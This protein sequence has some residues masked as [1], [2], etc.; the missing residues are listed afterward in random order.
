VP[1]RLPR[2]QFSALLPIGKRVLGVQCTSPANTVAPAVSAPSPAYVGNVITT[3]S[4]SWSC[5]P[6]AYHYQWLRNGAAI[7]GATASSYTIQAG[8]ADVGATIRSSVQ[9]C[10]GIDCSSYVQSSN[11]VVPANR[12]P[13]APTNLVPAN[14]TI[15]NVLTPTLSGTFSDP[16]GQ[17]GYISFTVNR[18]A[19]GALVTNGSSTPQVNSGATAS[20]AVPANKLVPGAQY[21]WYAQAGD[22]SGASSSSVGPR[23]YSVPPAAP[24]LVTPTSGASVSTATPV[25]SASPGSGNAGSDPLSYQ[26][27]LATDPGFGFNT[28]V[29]DG[30]WTTTTTTW[31]VPAGLLKDGQTYYW[32]ARACGRACPD[33][34]SA[35]S[36]GQSLQ[37]RLPKL[38]IR[39]YWPIWSRGPL[40]VNEANGNL[41]LSVPGPSYPTAAGSM[42]ASLSYNSQSSAPDSGFG[43]G[44]ALNAG[45]DGSSPP[46]KLIDHNQS[47]ASPRFDA[48]ERI[49]ADGSTDYYSHVGSSNTYLAAPG[50]GAQL[51][52]NG[53]GSWTLLDS[54]GAI[55][56]FNPAASNGSATLKSAERVDASPGK[57]SLSYSFSTVDP[58]KI[59]SIADGQPGDPGL[60][61]LS[62]AWHSL[63]DT[64]TCTGAILCISG[65]DNVA[66]KY[67][68][69]GPNGES[70][71]LVR[72]NDGAR[73]LLQLGYSGSLVT[74]VK[75]ANDL[76]PTHA[77]PNYNGAHSLAITYQACPSSTAQC[78]IKVDDGPVTNQTPA[79]SSWSFVYH[80]G[81]V[82]PTAPRASHYQQLV[83]GDG[84]LGYWPLDE[85]GG[86]TAADASG[87]A[88]NGTYSGTYT[89]G[90]SGAL[91]GSGGG[92]AVGFSGGTVAG[93][94]PN[95]NLAAGA[96]NTVELWLNWNGTDGVMP[97]GFAGGGNYYDLF[98]SGGNF[99]FNTGCSD[100][101]G[102]TAPS[103]N[104]WHHVVAQFYNGDPRSGA[105]LWID[106]NQQSLTL[107]TG[108]PCS[109]TVTSSFDISGWPYTSAY[110][111]G[112][113]VD[114]VAIYPDALSPVAIKAHYEEGKHNRAA[115]GYTTLTPPR[116]QTQSCPSKCV[117]TYYDSL[118]HPIETLDILGNISESAYNAK[119]EL[120]WSEDAD[121]N[122]TD[123]LY[124]GPDGRTT[125]NPFI[126]DAL[127]RT[128]AP[129][130]DGAGALGRPVSSSRY[131]ETQIG[132][133]STAGAALQGLQASY[134]GN[135]NLAGRATTIENNSTIDYS[136]PSGGPPELPNVIHNFS[137][138][139]SGDLLVS[140]PG[141]YTFSEATS[142]GGTRLTID[143]AQAIDSWTTAAAAPPS[144]PIALAA[145]LHKLVFEYFDDGAP[146]LPQIH[147]HWACGGCSPQVADQVIP[148]L[149][150][151]P[152]WFNQTST[153]SAG[154]RLSF[155]H[156]A[157]PAAAHSD[158][159]LVQVGAT[160]LIT[161][162]LYDA[163][164]RVTQKV[165]PKGNADPSRTIDGQGNLQGAPDTNY[166]TTYAYYAAGET[167]APP[168]AAGCS[169][170]AVNQGQRLKSMTPHGVASTTFVYDLA[171]R[172]IAKTK[173]AG[174]TCLSY[175]AVGEG[176]LLS[177]QA[178]GDAQPT[179]FTYDPVGAQLTATDAS[180]AVTSSY[181]EQ[182]RLVHSIDSYGAEATFSYDSDGNQLSR[183]AAA[184]SLAGNPNYTTGYVYDDADR[185][186]SMTDPANRTYTFF[187]DS[188]GNLHAT[189]YPNGTFSWQDFNPDGWL[190]GL[191]NRHGSLSAPLPASVPV[192]SQSSPLV[193]Y[194]YS[195]DDLDGK[196]TQ[197]VRTGGGLSSQTTSYVYDSLGRLNQVALPSGTCRKY[198]FDLDSNRTEIQESTTGCAG[199][200]SN[201][202][203]YTY[204]QANPNSPGLDQ[205]TSVG[206][207]AYAYDSDG[208]MS[209]RGS[210]TI[211]WDG[212]DRMTSFAP[213]SG[214]SVSYGFDPLGRRRSRTTSN[215]A[216]T[217]RYLFDGPDE[218]PLF[219]TDGAGATTQS[220]V[221]GAESD[222]AHYGGPPTAGS[223][224]S[225]L[226]YN[227]HGDLAAEATSTGTRT[228]SYTY[229]A[230][231]AP[232]EAVPSNSTTD[233]WT[234][235]WD[236]QLDTATNLIQMGARPYDPAVGRF[237]AVDPVE[238]GS[239]NAYDYAGQDPV[240][241][242]DLDGRMR[243][244]PG[245][246][247]CQRT[248]PTQCSSGS[249]SY[250]GECHQIQQLAITSGAKALLLRIA[251]ILSE[252]KMNNNRFFRIGWGTHQGRRVFRV[253]VGG[254]GAA[255][256]VGR[257]LIR[258]PHWHLWH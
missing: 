159:G 141:S 191:Y 237:L 223:T 53:D 91:A 86:T 253:V 125:A 200:F 204:D 179:S 109:R 230:F 15:S 163:Q 256:R 32:R 229:D 54:D 49:S 97:F 11:S 169:G 96:Y 232:N 177:T 239:L 87:N 151:R 174:T 38:G 247:G 47:G 120:L 44:W 212:W 100:V 36:A 116:Q 76:D 31:T 193:D 201:T 13:N 64:G 149:N 168:V 4:G 70:G 130:P 236:K 122:P 48:V 6:T 1:R 43:S 9:A 238:G 71:K 128:S 33:D 79:T 3:N 112:G 205:L 228:S 69:D 21:S 46:S 7:S 143:G 83:L 158:Y 134:Y 225:F 16:D 166:A 104:A 59:K 29:I 111:M 136:W 188:R 28:I 170:S 115:D 62:F 183:T 146:T 30:N 161:S 208:R 213:A 258:L 61:T 133:L 58:S 246:P 152:A 140:S 89:P 18:A 81:T 233:R 198:L 23:T 211:G 41:V 184:G 119:D 195:Y 129:D 150:L 224:V 182:G 242:Y 217:T 126:S 197:E 27:E 131:D 207:T 68:G 245:A 108:T 113:K 144:R 173:G 110:R 105:K 196:K 199:N 178:P 187:Y 142:Y 88:N 243:C 176:R 154:G 78:V 156:F 12:A 165:M 202:A 206:G 66:W 90:Q 99:G 248:R 102:V 95:L 203:T 220:Y 251:D 60:R 235:R 82:T 240:N 148:A 85:T 40:A 77:S 56:T 147:L 92:S 218:T 114:E 103:A 255:V 14:P 8:N 186:Q 98:F 241:A 2:L 257:R 221:Q 189:Q 190:T 73:D 39:D 171:G 121:G 244:G 175:D 157:D 50:D 192:D 24:T 63:A 194:S 155:S 249:I 74:S 162:Y 55:Y 93:S 65:P 80:P 117:T 84:P 138:R 10:N 17:T 52:K 22:H 222:L 172:P 107:K 226:Y 118:G 57:G 252:S 215:P 250:Q 254:P 210:A 123:L 45:D 227:G 5:P 35:W 185:L 101:Y 181:D 67:I 135:P 132:T 214:T 25:L 26:F 20:W 124:G 153:L 180:G 164:G 34:Y 106:G 42:A 234:G 137:V 216:K 75:N 167:A 209:S 160:N 37:V 51:T 94:L 72:V 139:W 231:G 19:T 127:L 145:G 219:E